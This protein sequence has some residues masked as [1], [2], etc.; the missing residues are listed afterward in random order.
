MLRSTKYQVITAFALIGFLIMVSF[1]FVQAPSGPQRNMMAPK[2]LKILPKN[3]EH[4]QLIHIMDEFCMSL[5]YKCYNCHA[6]AASGHGLDFA[7]DG[8]HEKI[9]ARKMMKMVIKLNK[10]FFNIK[11]SFADNFISAKYEVSCYSCHHGSEHPIKIAPMMVR[12]GGP[13]P[14]PPPP[15]HAPS[16]EN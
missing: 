3:I 1:A 14:P 13:P 12:P 16:Q 6:A 9:T 4:E 8:K 11:G 10:K 15:P 7:S 2:N 5:G